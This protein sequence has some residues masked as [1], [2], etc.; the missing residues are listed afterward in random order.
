MQTFMPYPDYRRSLECL[1]RARLGKQRVEA[2]QI[3]SALR[4]ESSGWINHPAV[5]MWREHLPAL[6]EYYNLSLQVWSAR[7]YRN[8]LLLPFPEIASPIKPPWVGNRQFHRSHQSNLV[9]KNP[10]Y[11]RKFFPH[12]SCNLPY[13][14]PV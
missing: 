9:R 6:I 11:Y 4:G 7:G 5:R 13:V 2:F 12:V 8:V 1:D 14:W 10:A 3:I